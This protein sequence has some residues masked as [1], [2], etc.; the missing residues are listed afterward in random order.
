MINRLFSD[1]ASE[2]MTELGEEWGKDIRDTLLLMVEEA[3]AE[4]ISLRD[5]TTLVIEE[6]ILL[7]AETRLGNGIKDHGK[8]VNGYAKRQ[9]KRVK[10][11]N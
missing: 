7:A 4:G 1:N 9:E 5:L 6:M 11:N 3:N 8:Q 10:F 2:K